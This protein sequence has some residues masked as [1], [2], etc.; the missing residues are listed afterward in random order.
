[1]NAAGIK[2]PAAQAGFGRDGNVQNAY[3]YNLQQEL[4]DVKLPQWMLE[5]LSRL[6]AEQDIFQLEQEEIAILAHAIHAYPELA[7]ILPSVFRTKIQNQKPRELEPIERAAIII[8]AVDWRVI[9]DCFDEG[10]IGGK[11]HAKF[12]AI[13]FALRE[14]G[15]DGN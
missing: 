10:T 14:G 12:E 6:A 7:E 11:I 1:M 15:Y 8:E 5:K 4:D 2:K 3:N 9:V 13:A